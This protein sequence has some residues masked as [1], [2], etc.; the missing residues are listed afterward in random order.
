MG[1][2]GKEEP[3]IWRGAILAAAVVGVL[4]GVVGCIV[5][6]IAISNTNNFNSYLPVYASRAIPVTPYAIYLDQAALPVQLTLPYDLTNRIGNI[7]RIWSR[8]EQPHFIDMV[9]MTWDGVNNR[10]V[11]GGAIGDGLVFEVISPTRV[12]LLSVV[13]VHFSQSSL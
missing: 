8:S 1:A 10:A 2:K 4:A 7:Y 6:G 12:A 9:Q 11:F 13:N 3:W 5:G